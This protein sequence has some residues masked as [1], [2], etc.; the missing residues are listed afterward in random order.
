MAGAETIETPLLRVSA[1]TAS[2]VAA[3]SKLVCVLP[4]HPLL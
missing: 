1:S 2:P 3:L 4:L